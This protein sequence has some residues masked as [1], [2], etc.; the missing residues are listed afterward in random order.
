MKKLIP[1]ILILTGSM[2]FWTSCYYDNVQDLYPNNQACD[3]TNV[4][5]THTIA[6]IMSA[7][8]NVCHSGLNPQKSITT[9]NWAGLNAAAAGGLDSQLWQAVSHSM[10]VTPMPYQNGKL[11][12]CDLAKIRVWI[13]AGA[14]NN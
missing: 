8:C 1:V 14:L 5:Y 10:K 13:N 12:E 4:T 2:M 11:S 6:P 7:N 9:D 3:S